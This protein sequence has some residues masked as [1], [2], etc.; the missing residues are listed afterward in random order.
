MGAWSRGWAYGVG[1]DSSKQARSGERLW[2]ARSMVALLAVGLTVSSCGLL[3]EDSPESG[4]LQSE[5]AAD[6]AEGDAPTVVQATQA[7]QTDEEL[8]AGLVALEQRWQSARAENVR[9]L[10]S[11]LGREADVDSDEDADEV[12]AIRS[13]GDF[14][15]DLEECP[16]GWNDLAGV[17]ADTIRIALV[18]AQTGDRWPV[19]AV[20]DGL[21]AYIGA[22]NDDGGVGG[23]RIELVI[24]DDAFDPEL[25][26]TVVEE[27][28]SE[29][30]D[31]GETDDGETQVIDEDAVLAVAT[32]GAQPSLE[33][34]EIL[35]E[36]CVPQP[37]ALTS[38]PGLGDPQDNPWTTSLQ[39][40]HS[41][42]ALLWGNWMKRNLIDDL[43]V[44]IGMVVIDNEF[45]DMYGSI[46][47][48]WAD[49]SR[50]VVSGL[51]TVRHDPAGEEFTEDLVDLAESPPDILVVATSGPAC[52][53]V[54]RDAAALGLTNQVATIVSSTC[55]DPE[56]YMGPAGNAA[57]GV[58]MLDGSVK[59]T[60]NP[61]FQNDPFVR[62]ISTILADAGIDT[63]NPLAGTGAGLVGWTLVESL[64][65]A[66]ELPGGLSRS[67]LVLAQRALDLEHPYLIEG[68][69]FA[70]RGL[71]DAFFLEASELSRFD[72]SERVWI[73]EP[74][75]VDINGGT[76]TCSWSGT[77]CE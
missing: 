41:T 53:G 54:L 55:K 14:E 36:A 33:A 17:D 65:I 22:V 15:L 27:L 30:E 18:V 61:R 3:G 59:S 45:G 52:A 67:N 49:A 69:Q 35:N 9:V 38:H 20:G 75:V 46:F 56:R 47:A 2:L 32:V 21:S 10:T 66:S 68:M 11:F 60:T 58:L 5:S 63:S 71:D 29:P 19:K 39:L 57:D 31:A 51:T 26:A 70:S 8:R 16:D 37:L 12:K 44:S 24:K 43:P 42:E 1:S 7:T 34:M 48:D 13:L 73:I 40:A 50:D 6:V 76:P 28:V 64:R 23:R 62:E 74:I 4:V 25:T 72:A 77:A